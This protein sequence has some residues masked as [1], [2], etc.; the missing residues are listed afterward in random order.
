M[1]DPQ[2]TLTP[3]HPHHLLALIESEAAFAESFGLPAAKGLREFMVG[4]EASAD[5]LAALRASSTPSPFEHGFAVTQVGGGEVIGMLAFKGL[6][7]DRGVVEIAYGIVPGCEGQGL[8]TAAAGAGTTFAFADERVRC[9]RAHTLPEVNAS[10]R[11]LQKNGFVKLGEVI[12][13]EDGRV[14]RWERES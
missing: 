8:A 5:W 11:V 13:P 9:V 1:T 6:P 14:W 7:D 4:G 12:D 2:I 3:W 10:T